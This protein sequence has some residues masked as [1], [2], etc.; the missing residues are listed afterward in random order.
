LSVEFDC[1]RCT[2]GRFFELDLEPDKQVGA[3]PR[4]SA[5]RAEE[6]AEKARTSEDIPECREN[7]LGRPEVVHARPFKSSVTIAVVSRTLVRVGENFVSLGRFT[8]FPLGFLIA[9]VAVGVK[10][11]GLLPISSLDLIGR[12]AAL[13]PEN[14]V[15]VT[16]GRCHR[17]RVSIGGT[18]GGGC[19][20]LYGEVGTSYQQRHETE[21]RKTKRPRSRRDSDSRR[22]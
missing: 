15:I 2:S 10:P 6:I 20:Q 16:L 1:S 11:L 22:I 4:T 5:S 9:R 14:L 13:E 17:H 7:F 8:E 21:Y 19:H 3:R 12:G 18:G